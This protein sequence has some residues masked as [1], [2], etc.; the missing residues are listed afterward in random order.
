MSRSPRPSA[1]A[2]AAALGLA[3][4]G[5]PAAA[6]CPNAGWVLVEPKASP[7]TRPVR[8]L[9]NHRI[10]VRRDQI[11]TTADLT[12]IKLAGDAYDTLI[13]MRFT[14]QAAQR[15]HDATTNRSGLRIAFVSDDRALSSITWTGPY[16]MDADQ[17][18]QISLGKAVPKDRPLV[19]AIQR[20]LG[21]GGR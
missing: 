1:A 14:P 10:F 9:P 12:Q 5:S 21:R 11:T 15:L 16:G 19:A 20:C 7:Q 3:F 4:L 2:C 18:V 17:G 13:Q 8:A 6:A